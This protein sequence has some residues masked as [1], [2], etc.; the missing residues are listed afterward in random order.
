MQSSLQLDIAD[1]VAML[2]K[3]NAKKSFAA[4]RLFTCHGGLY[5]S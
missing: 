2:A 3:C 4:L 5:L 1:T